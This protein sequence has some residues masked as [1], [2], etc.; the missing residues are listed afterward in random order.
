MTGM[1]GLVL[2]SYYLY[3][4]SP[5]KIV[6]TP[7]GGARVWRISIDT[8]GWLEENELFSE[9]VFAVGGEI[10]SRRVEE[11]VQEV[12]AYRSHYLSGEGPVFALYETIKAIE[13]VA[14]QERRDLTAREIA[15]IR[16]I[17][18]KTFVIFE[19]QLQRAGDQGADPGLA[20]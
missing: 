12:E 13:E 18:R 1:P 15:L 5:V 14:E 17:R 3:Y 11:F 2:P 10:F 19:E 4:A 20:A 7:D 16:G 9:I 8:G 6:A